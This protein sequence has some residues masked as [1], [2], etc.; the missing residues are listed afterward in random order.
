VS[1]QW[2]A[3]G[4]GRERR[5]RHGARDVVSG[6]LRA[7]VWFLN[8]LSRMQFPLGKIDVIDIRVLR[9][10]LVIAALHSGYCCKYY[11]VSPGHCWDF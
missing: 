4:S 1:L 10:M 11:F 9:K 5:S 3:S 8:L 2:S 7:T 6:Q